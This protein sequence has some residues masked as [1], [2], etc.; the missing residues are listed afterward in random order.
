MFGRNET[1]QNAIAVIN[2]QLK[3]LHEVYI[4]AIRDCLGCFSTIDK[5]NDV[6][7]KYGSLGDIYISCDENDPCYFRLVDAV[8][9]GTATQENEI[10]ALRAINATAHL[11]CAKLA[12][13]SYNGI[14]I[15]TNSV[16]AF[17]APKDEIPS[18]GIIRGTLER[19]TQILSLARQAFQK[20][21]EDLGGLA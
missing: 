14:L 16:E 4:R 21:L 11:K 6:H 18:E 7:F 12:L 1:N 15:L 10:K 2:P 17:L 3:Q 19:Y 8:K 5:D 13:K 9:I 20:E